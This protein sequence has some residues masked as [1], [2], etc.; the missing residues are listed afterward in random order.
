M[1]QK[2]HPAMQHAD[3]QNAVGLHTIKHNMTFNAHLPQS[4]SD[5]A[6]ILPQQWDLRQT[7]K[8]LVQADDILLCALKS[9]LRY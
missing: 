4:R 8:H 1:T 7:S 2:I 5:I 3:N 9:P 6:T